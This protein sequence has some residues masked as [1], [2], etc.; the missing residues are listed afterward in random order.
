MSNIY[1]NSDILNS[2]VILKDIDCSIPCNFLVYFSSSCPTRIINFSSPSGVDIFEIFMILLSLIPYPLV[3]ILLILAGYFRTSRSIFILGL[4]FLEN[5]IVVILKIIIQEPRPNY[6]CNN[7]YGFPSNH[8][9]FCTC[10]LFWF[11]LEEFYTPKIL[12]IQYKILIIFFAM[13]YPLILY[14][15]YYLNYHSINQILG[16]L[17]LG[18][19]ISIGWF[20]FCIKYIL[21]TDNIIKQI[22]IK[23][24]IQNNLTFD[25]LAK[26]DGYLLLDQY[27][28]LIKTENELKEMKNKLN[29]M[30]NNMN[31][32][33]E[34]DKYQKSYEDF[35][36][37]NEN[38]IFNEEKVD[39]DEIKG[40]N[41]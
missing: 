31:I 1:Q 39:N 26:S 13:I 4:L 36:K 10:I 17:I 28:N 34:L 37:N 25:I 9:C 14:S 35:L 6:L 38:Q 40:N 5:F 20:F 19:F 41:E 8:S 23:I 33:D 11:L 27:Q 32:L 22:M 30:K 3:F 2:P 15:R 16:G 7:E 12:Q 29:Q 24:G 18:I 21:N